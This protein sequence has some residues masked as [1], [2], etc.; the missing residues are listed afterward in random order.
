[1]NPKEKFMLM[2]TLNAIA[3]DVSEQ[4]RDSYLIAQHAERIPEE[5]IPPNVPNAA[6]VYVRQMDGRS[7]P[8]TWMIPRRNIKKKGGVK[9]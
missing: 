5:N 7:K 8:F 3:R 1:M 2:V 9:L 4:R 6:Q